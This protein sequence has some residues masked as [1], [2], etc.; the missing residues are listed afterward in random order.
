MDEYFKCLS[1]SPSPEFDYVSVSKAAYLGVSDNVQTVI[2]ENCCYNQVLNE[3]VKPLGPGCPENLLL[4][5][6]VG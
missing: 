1:E 3:T 2:F 4:S 5:F 6:L